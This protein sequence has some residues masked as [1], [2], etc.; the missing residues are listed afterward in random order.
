MYK[1]TNVQMSDVQMCKCTDFQTNF[2]QKG[3]KKG[4]KRR[5][6]HDHCKDEKEFD[7]LAIELFA[8]QYANNLPFRQFAMQQGSSPRMAKTW[9]DIPPVPINA[10]KSVL[11]SC[12]VLFDTIF[13][14]SSICRY[15]T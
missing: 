12:C 7:E 4:D 2:K 9:R 15:C 13:I 1:C 10:F 5:H 3:C 6:A 11:L 8:Y 14:C